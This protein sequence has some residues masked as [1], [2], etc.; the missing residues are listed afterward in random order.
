MK[1][2]SILTPFMFK[3]FLV[4]TCITLGFGSFAKCDAQ[5]IIG[6]WKGVSVKNYYSAA[7]AKEVGKPM[8]EKSAKEL[9]NSAIEYKSDHTFLMTFSAINDPHV[10]TMYG[11]WSQTGDEL[12]L[13]MEPKYNPQKMTTTAT[14]SIIGN[15][16]L[17]TAVI[18]PPSRIIKTISLS[19]RM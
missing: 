13:T 19:T 14:F 8:D 3:A 5:S 1:I 12:K 7:Y 18:P 17:M 2:K 9:G 11:S 15:T 4:I 16:M 6:K 10:T